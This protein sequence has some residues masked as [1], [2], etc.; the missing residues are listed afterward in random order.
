MLRHQDGTNHGAGV[1][2]TE[3]LGERGKPVALRLWELEG[4]VFSL[5]AG[6]QLRAPV[7]TCYK[8]RQ[9]GPAGAPLLCLSPAPLWAGP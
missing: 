2:L 8:G 1:A 3:Q 6:P 7:V 4:P 9:S 5:L